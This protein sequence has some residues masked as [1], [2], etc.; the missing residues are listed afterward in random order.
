[1]NTTEYTKDFIK[2]IVIDIETM[3]NLDVVKL[4]PEPSIDAR[5][6]DPVKVAEAQS[7]AKQKQLDKMGLSPLTGK[8]ACIGYYS[9]DISLVHITNEAE[10][11]NV[12]YDYIKNYQIITYNGKAF[13]V[14]YIFKRGIIL[15]LP[16][17][18]IPEMKKYTDKYN[19]THIDLMTEFCNWGD[20]EKL[21]NLAR[22]ILGET[23]SEFDFREIPELLKTEEGKK[24]ITDY[25]L[26]DC[27]LTWQLAKR[28]GFVK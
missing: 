23:K 10:M 4:L 6:K 18:T 19:Q 21:D 13:D 28:M 3:P 16:W 5:L 2:Q 7:E 14:P 11:L 26:Q 22:F 17:A 1:M 24:K 27:K 12:V 25:C 15:G 8:I 20:F 9:D